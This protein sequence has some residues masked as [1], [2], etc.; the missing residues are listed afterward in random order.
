[1]NIT[2][3]QTEEHVNGKVINRYGDA[4]IRGNNGVPIPFPLIRI[5]HLIL[6][7]SVLYISASESLL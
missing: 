5:L 6:P 7:F 4:F 3:E 1:M 2:L